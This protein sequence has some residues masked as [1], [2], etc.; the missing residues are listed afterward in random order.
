MFDTNKSQE[1]L[2]LQRSCAYNNQPQVAQNEKFKA[3]KKNENFRKSSSFQFLSQE[4]FF[5]K[6]YFSACKVSFRIFHCMKKHV[7]W[8]KL[9][10][11]SKDSYWGHEC[12]SCKYAFVCFICPSLSGHLFV[13]VVICIIF[14]PSISKLLKSQ[15]L[16]FP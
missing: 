9:C 3:E 15:N 2:E 8:N 4:N 6:S 5:R 12:D 14:T 11:F 7:F 1:M 16:L 13:W 10:T